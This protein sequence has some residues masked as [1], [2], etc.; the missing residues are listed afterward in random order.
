LGVRTGHIARHL[1]RLP[2]NQQ[3]AAKESPEE[4]VVVTDG[5]GTRHSINVEMA[6]TPQKREKGLMF[7]RALAANAGMLFIFPKDQVVDFWMKDTILPLD[8]IFIR[9]D[10]IVASI[11]RDEAPFSLVNTF[12][13]GPVVATLEVPAGTAARFGLKQGDMVVPAPCPS[14]D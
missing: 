14:A 12:S 2:V 5:A 11:A 10:G 1:W 7:R 9:E 6:V 8:M 3:P 13:A 4:M